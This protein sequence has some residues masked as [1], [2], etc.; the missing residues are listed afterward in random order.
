M[1]LEDLISKFITGGAGKSSESSAT[2][3]AE[4]NNAQT[5]FVE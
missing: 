1:D 5:S 2:E 3:T 4:A